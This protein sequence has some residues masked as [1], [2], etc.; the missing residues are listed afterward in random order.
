MPK[1]TGPLAALTLLAV[2]PGCPDTQGFYDDFA[3]R[4]EV[5]NPSSSSGQTCTDGP[6]AVGEADGPYLFALSTVLFPPTPILFEG[7]LTTTEQDGNLAWTM[8]LQPLDRSDR[9]TPV[10]ATI[11]LA[12]PY[13]VAADGTF[14]AALP[15]LFVEGAA[16]PLTGNDI[17]AA[18]TLTGTM[19]AT[20]EFFC[21]DAMGETVQ[22]PG[23]SI[24]GTTWT[25]DPLPQAG[26][27]YPEPP[28][29]NCAGDLANP[30]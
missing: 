10:G 18:A 16:N 4:Y 8:V 30:L 21:G 7:T 12:G 25:L 15:L 19:C 6:P 1:F 27:P 3:A 9:E 14:T 2:L 23:I 29:I 28:K 11:D 26:P 5:I 22:P 20:D 13:P 24:D 17:E